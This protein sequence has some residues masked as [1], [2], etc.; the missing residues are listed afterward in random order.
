MRGL[1]LTTLIKKACSSGLMV[2]QTLTRDL[3]Q[4]NL[5]TVPA[6]EHCVLMKYQDGNFMDRPC[7]RNQP[8]ICEVNYESL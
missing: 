1:V 7:T 5:I 4:T 2:L 3:M 6:N 8:F